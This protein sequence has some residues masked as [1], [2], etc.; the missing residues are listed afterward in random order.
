MCLCAFRLI[1]TYG[2]G[3][4][5]KNSLKFY[6]H[7]SSRMPHFPDSKMPHSPDAFVFIRFFLQLPLSF[8]P[9]QTTIWKKV[10]YDRFSE[11]TQ[12]SEGCADGV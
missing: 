7:L 10:T 4:I 2:E 5:L 8:C 11:I 1:L 6:L 3:I 9:F 12:W